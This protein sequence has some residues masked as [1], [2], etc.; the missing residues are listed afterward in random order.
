MSVD[1]PQPASP[2]DHP[3]VSSRYFFPR[4][5]PPPDPF[6]V[7]CGEASLACSLHRV[8]PAAPTLVH[9]HGNGEVVADWLPDLP[10]WVGARGWNL[11]LAEYRG[12][13][14]S[15]GRPALVGMLA[16]VPAIHAALGAPPGRVAVFGRSLGS[17]YALEYA[18]RV[19]G[20]AGLVLESG[21][22][23][24]LE[25]VL[26][27]VSPEELGVTLGELQAEARRHLDHRAKL[28][29]FRGRLLVL[30]A[31]GDDLVGVDHARRNFEWCA[32]PEKELV[33]LPRGDHN[34]IL[35][36]NADQYLEALGRFLAACAG[37]TPGM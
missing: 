9:F 4:R 21:I 27:R 34:S 23:D 3:L 6:E 8:D 19:P 31:R 28:G 14:G 17:I 26:L 15:S 2:F 18:H 32:S 13:G 10:R 35:V 1:G 12:Y 33:V 16:D 7:R 22:A 37:S 20:I 11:L 29:G 5:E 25:R 24:P 30:H 36:A